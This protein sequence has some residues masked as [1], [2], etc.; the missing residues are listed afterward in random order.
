[1][2][3]V[4]IDRLSKNGHKVTKVRRALA[5]IFETRHAPLTAGEIGKLLTIKSIRADKTTVYREVEFL[6]EQGLLEAV[7]LGDRSLRYERKDDDHHHHVVCIKCR[8]VVDVEMQDDLSSQE[9]VIAKKTG[10]R[11]IR[12]TLEFFGLCKSCH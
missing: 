9:K 11:D 6:R 12:H 7:S 10:F 2:P 8:T 1:M 5:E 3:S 4:I